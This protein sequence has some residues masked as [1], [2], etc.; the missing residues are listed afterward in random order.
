M[1]TVGVYLHASF[2]IPGWGLNSMGLAGWKDAIDWAR[3]LGMNAGIISLLPQKRPEHPDWTLPELRRFY[4][5]GVSQRPAFEPWAI[6]WPGD[7]LLATPE[8]KAGADVVSQAMVYAR[9]VGLTPYAGLYMTLGSPTFAL[10]HPELQAVGSH[11]F[12]TEGLS[13][14]PSKPEA[15][16]HLKR[17]WGDVIAAQPKDVEF[18]LWLCDPGGCECPQCRNA[19]GRIIELVETYYDIIRRKRPAAKIIFNSWGVV[20][21]DIRA[22]AKGISKDVAIADSPLI[23]SM[24]RSIEEYVERLEAWQRSGHEV[25]AWVETQENPTY[26]LPPCYPKRIERVMKVAHERQLAGTWGTGTIYNY[27]FSL[28]YNVLAGLV[29]DVNATAE[30]ITAEYLEQAFGKDARPAGM[31]WAAAMEDVW[32]RVYAPSQPA[33]GFM[34]IHFHVFAGGMLPEKLMREEPH[35]KA[36]ED[37]AAAVVAAETAVKAI[38]RVAASGGWRF[39]SIDTH[40]LSISTQLIL[41]RVKFRQA[42]FPVLA[43][44][45]KGDLKTAVTTFDKLLRLSEEM[46][47]TARSAPNTYLLTTHWSKLALW[48]ERLKALRLHLPELV[49]ERKYRSIWAL[50]TGAPMVGLTVGQAERSNRSSR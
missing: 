33:S 44:I 22:A 26:L 23:H 7:P 21:G 50:S 24:V 48:P 30:Q 25:H 31:E 46:I 6:Y 37:V 9:R 43:A 36:L 35:S 4:Y 19:N 17:F 18:M 3:A 27:I 34:P 5:A 42:K 13:L 28:N 49:Q 10:E 39:H 14:C 47:V 45:R 16:E 32:T 8:A 29:A 12:C 41:L 40:V 11:D 15:M 1:K 20:T 38:Q 2:D